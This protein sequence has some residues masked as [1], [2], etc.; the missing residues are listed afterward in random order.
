MWSLW[1]KIYL[2]KTVFENFM[3]GGLKGGFQLM[4]IL[5]L[6][7]TYFDAVVVEVFT[8]FQIVSGYIVRMNVLVKFPI[9]NTETNL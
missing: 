5:D 7:G 8:F 2:K 3:K 1:R 9:F 6:L 4:Q